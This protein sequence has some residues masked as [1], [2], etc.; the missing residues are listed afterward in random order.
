[1]GRWLSIGLAFLTMGAGSCKGKVA[2]VIS[3][4]T[5]GKYHVGEQ[6]NYRARPGEDG[7]TLIVGKVET[8]PK[9]GVI[10][11]ISLAGLRV[12]NSHATTGYSDTIAHMPFSEAALEK[13]VTTLASS[14]VPVPPAFAEGYGEWRQA[15]D[16]GKAGAFTITVA[17]GVDFME[18]VLSQ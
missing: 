4:V 12:K 3:A 17:E 15:F 1:L 13:S 5:N 18:Q 7:S 14:S 9:L 6:W 8:M 16:R 2:P 11:H 10:V